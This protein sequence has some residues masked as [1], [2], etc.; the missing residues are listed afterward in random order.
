[1][2]T[3]RFTFK[4]LPPEYADMGRW[5]RIDVSDLPAD[6]QNRFS[7]LKRGIEAYVR[8]GKLKV[9]SKESGYSEDFIIKQLNRCVTVAN[10]GQLWGWAGLLK[11]VRIKKYDR[12]SP[13]PTGSKGTVKGFSG[14]FSKFLDEH[15]D[16]RNEL[17]A[18]ILKKKTK[19]RI[20]EAR[21]SIE[22]LKTIFEDMCRKY[23]VRE[24]EYPLN[25]ISYA[26]R[27]IGRYATW[28]IQQDISSG[29]EARFG[30]AAAKH[31]SVATGESSIPLALAPYDVGGLDAHEIHCIGCVIVPGP[32]GPQRVAVER[33][34]VICNVDDISHAILGYSVGIRTE[35]SSATVEEALISTTAQWQPRQL[36]IPGLSYRQ[37][38]GLPSGVIPELVGCFPAILRLDNAAPHFAKR[39][40]ESARKHLGCALTWGPIG[41]WEHNAVTERLFK[42]LE[43]YGFQRLPSTTGSNTTDPIKDSPVEQATKIG[44]TWE[45]LLDLTDVLVADYNATGNRGLGG[46]SPLQVLR[47]HL[48]QVE[49]SFLPRM[50]PPATMGQPELGVVV[51]TRFI[52]GNQKQGR[53]PYVEIDRVRYTSPILARSFG[54]VGTQIRLHIRESNMCV[55]GAFFESGQELG[56]LRAQGKWWRTP[57]TREMRK[58]I[59]AL[60][61]A[62]ELALSPDDDPVEKLLQ[63]YASKA[64]HDALKRPKSVSKAATNLASAANV[65]GLPVPPA[66]PSSSGNELPDDGRK[67]SRPIP[68]TIKSP[69]WKS[70]T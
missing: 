18:R 68:S 38:S 54:L 2:N 58:K 14:C 57:H 26:R 65:S 50:L 30:K 64:Y 13:L 12:R 60:A 5:R 23:G 24:N 69:I 16:I 46:Q 56:S 29:T 48:Q 27:S 37:G 33:L 28:L 43:T 62:G 67:T 35:V 59:M 61:D 20:H 51:E 3:R 36:T 10:D 41:H 55:V 52:R 47:N 42:T 19:G 70:V 17:D 45:A 9:A 53:R 32:A 7:N 44:I 11:G 39:I 66:A 4:T 31:L 1:M 8:T 21:I 22:K 49:P 63:Y 34:W 6:D 25:V 15:D 40:A